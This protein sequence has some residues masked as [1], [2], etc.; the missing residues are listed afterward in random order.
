[1]RPNV[2]LCPKAEILLENNRNKINPA[3]I[4]YISLLRATS[5]ITSVPQYFEQKY[6]VSKGARKQYFKYRILELVT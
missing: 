6:S 3:N 4:K 5:P 1:M 2:I